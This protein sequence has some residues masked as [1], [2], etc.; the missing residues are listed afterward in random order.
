MLAKELEF[1]KNL[2]NE[3]EMF[4][5]SIPDRQAVIGDEWTNHF[6]VRF[7]PYSFT[8]DIAAINPLNHSVYGCRF[9]GWNRNL[10]FIIKNI[11]KFHGPYNNDFYIS[12]SDLKEIL[13][14]EY[15]DNYILTFHKTN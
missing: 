11:D 6:H 10:K 15:K 3:L 8:L 2:V 7:E 9:M 12:Y 13:F 14:S 1:R 4:G 5:C